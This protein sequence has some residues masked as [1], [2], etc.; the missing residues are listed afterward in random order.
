M[1]WN[2]IIQVI[3]NELAE[4]GVDVI[5]KAVVGHSAGGGIHQIIEAPIISKQKTQ[6]NVLVVPLFVSVGN[7]QTRMIPDAIQSLE[8]SS[9]IHRFFRMN[10]CRV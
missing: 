7:F 8:D 6:G 9:R 1:D 5:E 3:G 10:P 2:S 4:I